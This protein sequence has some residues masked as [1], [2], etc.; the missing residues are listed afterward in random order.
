MNPSS[1]SF[2]GRPPIVVWGVAFEG[3]LG[4]IAV[5]VGWWFGYP[6]LAT[7]RWSGVDALVGIAASLPMLLGFCACVRWP[8]GPL[9]RIKDFS[10]DV[11]RPLFAGCT[12]LE[13]GLISL[14]AGVGE[15]MLFRGLLQWAVS[16]WCGIYVGIAAASIIFGLM[17]LITPTYGML[18]ALLGVYLGG[19]WFLNGNLLSVI[20]AHG[21]YDF[22]ALVYLVKRQA[23]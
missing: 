19:V 3:A 22:V 14:A 7:F 15:E 23:A 2:L 18:A 17:H 4:A 1:G 20:I 12:I 9:E 10:D 5:L 16:D 21:L 13:L 11:I 8:V 6:P